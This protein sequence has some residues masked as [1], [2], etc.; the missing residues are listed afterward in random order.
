MISIA[1]V[2]QESQDL[3]LHVQLCAQRYAELDSRLTSL[4]VKTD[5]ILAEIR[6]NKIEITKIMIGT[7]GTIITSML[8]LVVTILMKF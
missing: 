8:A 4:E 2:D 3:D 5:Q 7:G 6:Q 1:T